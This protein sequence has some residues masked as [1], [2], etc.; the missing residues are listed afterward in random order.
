[1]DLDSTQ[2]R[3]HSHKEDLIGYRRFCVLP[4]LT[5][6]VVGSHI[7]G[8]SEPSTLASMPSA[9]QLCTTTTAFSFAPIRHSTGSK[10]G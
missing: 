7:I 4:L 8:S 3:Q 1:M 10:N 2:P 5:A 6:N 9:Y